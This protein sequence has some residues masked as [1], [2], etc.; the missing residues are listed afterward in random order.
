MRLVSY[1][2]LGTIAGYIGHA[3]NIG[4]SYIGYQQ[5]FG[6]IAGSMLV[7]WGLKDL[8]LLGKFPGTI[9][10]GIAPHITQCFRSTMNLPPILRGALLGFFSGILPCGWLYAFVISAAATGDPISGAAIMAAFWLGTVPALVAFGTI[11]QKLN[12]KVLAFL[13]RLAAIIILTLG[14]LTITGKLTPTTS[15]SHISGRCH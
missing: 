15:H 5:M 6:V 1:T 12:Q 3:A 2:L 14:L 4:S 8:G 13:P 9:K 10:L 7:L 11:V